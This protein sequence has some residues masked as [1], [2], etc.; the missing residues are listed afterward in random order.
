MKIM[1]MMMMLRVLMGP[2]AMMMMMMMKIARI[3][4]MVKGSILRLKMRVFLGVLSCIAAASATTL[5]QVV[6]IIR[7]AIT[8]I[9]GTITICI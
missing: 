2:L 1:T 9:I 4:C 7:I 8:I 3:N 6:S 5:L